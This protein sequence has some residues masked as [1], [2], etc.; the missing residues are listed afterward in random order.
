MSKA[1]KQAIESNDASAV[2]KAMKSVKDLSKKLPKASPP[3]EYAA[4]IGAERAMEALL[5]GGAPA[6]GRGALGIGHPFLAAAEKGHAAVLKVLARHG[7][8][9]DNVVRLALV[10]AAR[11]GQDEAVGTILAECRPAI[12]PDVIEVAAQE[13]GGRLLPL[14]LEHGADVNARNDGNATPEWRGV[15]ALQAIAKSGEAVAIRRLL[16]AGAD[17]NAQDA[18]GR[19]AL[20]WL[21]EHVDE[22]EFVKRR[23]K[24]MA[25]AGRLTGAAANSEPADGLAT[26]RLLLERGA[27]ARLTDRFGNDALMCQQ[28]AC[29][30]HGRGWEPNEKSVA[31]LRNAG[32]VGGG[33]TL[34]L[35]KAIKIDDV[36]AVRAAI[37][38]GADVNRIAPDQG[39]TPLIWCHSIEAVSAL[40]AAGADPNKPAQC[41]LPL[42]SAARSGE[43]EVVKRLVEAGADIHAIEP[44]DP[45]S[46]YIANA[47]S[48]AQDNGKTEV[49]DY[50]RSLGAGKPR[51]ADWKP[52]AAGVHTWEDFSEILVKGD[53]AAVA[54]GLAQMIGG[55]AQLGVYGKQLKPGKRA[56]VVVRP[57]GMA[58]C[59]VWQLVP[60]RKRMENQTA[61]EKRCKEIAA[62]CNAPV[63]QV[64]YSDTSDAARVVRANTE[65]VIHVDE[66]WDRDS[67]EEMVT[68]LGADAPAWAKKRLSQTS[69][70]EPSSTQRLELLAAREKFVAAAFGFYCEGGMVEVDVSGYPAEAFDDAAFITTT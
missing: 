52:L 9:P 23:W 70:D 6:E 67:L 53:V 11:K 40:L 7:Q 47:Y 2:N 49:A 60:A 48:A 15:T 43:L 50:L 16:D 61:I 25:A 30:T 41:G 31:L 26:M 24:E 8:A 28:W 38:A 4:E 51:L 54:E 63:I 59:N 13:N 64:D 10:R 19:T 29:L 21:A 33:A 46:E 55:K 5:A 17:V 27:D 62:A 22:L 68:N 65:G 3:T 37:G 58:W 36:H 39:P 32:A 34:E 1:L 12:R 66:G 44:R 56:Y 45:R 42:V 69:D 18:R 14:L 35:F 20:M 57:K